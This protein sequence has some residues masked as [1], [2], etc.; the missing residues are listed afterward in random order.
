[1]SINNSNALL[2]PTSV[3]VDASP[4]RPELHVLTPFAALLEEGT[5]QNCIQILT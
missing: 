2:D 1:M 4:L 5:R 3:I